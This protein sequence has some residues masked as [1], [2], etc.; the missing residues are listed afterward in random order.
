[1]CDDGGGSDLD[2]A[3]Q[4]CRRAACRDGKLECLVAWLVRPRRRERIGPGAGSLCSSGGDAIGGYGNDRIIDRLIAGKLVEVD[5][6]LPVGD[7]GHQ[8][9]VGAG[10]FEARRAGGCRCGWRR[11][12]VGVVVTAVCEHRG[13][14]EDEKECCRENARHHEFP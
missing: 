2:L 1:M 5:R 7:S 12:V 11:L 6:Q 13:G 8:L 14:D 3:F 10:E 4:H 9:D